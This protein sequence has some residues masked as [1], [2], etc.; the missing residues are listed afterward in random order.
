MR[1]FNEEGNEADDFEWDCMLADYHAHVESISAQLS[2]D[3]LALATDPRL[4]SHDARFNEITVDREAPTV[5]M[6]IDCG[7]LQVGYRRVKLRF[8][9]GKSTCIVQTM[10]PSRLSPAGT[11]ASARTNSRDSTESDHTISVE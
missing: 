1:W 6:V 11:R 5:E 3:L 7:D 9:V 2:P 8:N 10:S 4:N